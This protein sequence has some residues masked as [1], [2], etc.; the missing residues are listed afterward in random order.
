LRTKSYCEILKMKTTSNRRWSQI[1]KT[2]ISHCMVHDL[3]VLRG[4]LEENQEEIL[5]V[6]LLSPACFVFISIHFCFL[7]VCEQTTL[8]WNIRYAWLLFC[9]LGLKE[10]KNG[11]NL[12]TNYY[13]FSPFFLEFQTLN[14][15]NAPVSVEGFKAVNILS[16]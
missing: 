3:W 14:F 1:I 2:G 13:N 11:L 6:A 4:K 5:S 10:R 15:L 16:C 12:T 8:S 9:A 7:L